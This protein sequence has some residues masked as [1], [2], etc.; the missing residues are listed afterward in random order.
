[1]KFHKSAK[2]YL[3]KDLIEYISS[4]S[5]YASSAVQGRPAQLPL[6]ASAL[7]L[8]VLIYFCSEVDP[9][10]QLSQPDKHFFK[11]INFFE[12]HFSPL[13]LRYTF[14][15]TLSIRSAQSHHDYEPSARCALSHNSITS[16]FQADTPKC[17]SSDCFIFR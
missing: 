1:M 16:Y 4:E 11:A 12:S 3:H 9:L 7:R 5:K 17:I 15:V 2:T 10:L 6:L 8:R 14:D 13:P